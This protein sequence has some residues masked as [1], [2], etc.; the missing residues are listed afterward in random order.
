MTVD[1]G[2]V[3]ANVR[4]L[5]SL[6]GPQT[7]FMAALKADAYGHGAL[8]VCQAVMQA[9]G[10]A[11]AL[12]TCEEA[13]ELRE[14]GVTAP[15]LVMG[16]LFA[17]SQLLELAR[18]GVEVALV[19]Q[20][21]VHMLYFLPKHWNARLHSIR[22]HIKVDSGM[23]RQGLFPHEIPALLQQLR[24]LR[25]RVEVVGVMT[26]FASAAEEPDSVPWQLERF[27]PCMAD[28]RGEWPAAIA[29]AANSAATM[30]HP[31]S[32][33]DMVRCGIAAYGMSPFQADPVSEGL[34]PV[35]SWTSEVAMTKRVPAGEGVGYGLTY[36]PRS[37]TTI[38][39]IPLGYA[40]G[41]FRVL[42][43]R[44]QVLI[45]GARYPM[46]GRVSMDSFAVDVG[47]ADTVH[48][49]DAV[50]L[51]GQD[52]AEAI[53]AE[54]MAAWAR[55]I[56]YEVTCAT[57]L[58]RAQRV[59]VDTERES[60]AQQTA[61]QAAAPQQTAVGQTAAEQAVGIPRDESGGAEWK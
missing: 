29:H 43:N 27:L 25:E 49:G 50:T 5:R 7:R 36:H 4:R 35:M 57:A 30:L 15:L 17:P 16:P 6:L 13:L 44:G 32:H 38:A 58:R 55:T 40:D 56:N 11:V 51:I 54:D 20:E 31:E 48:A 45:N 37:D 28:I 22:L 26:H 61:G 3:R 39:L 19:S 24:D 59:V 23:D 21:M 10:S 46:V 34:R 60:A 18:A 8:P 41:L 33:L 12:A 42:G 14:S 2:A 47:T 9:G 1:I 52:G 53:R